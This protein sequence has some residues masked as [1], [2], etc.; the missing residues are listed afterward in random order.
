MSLEKFIRLL[1]ILVACSSVFF[2]I[3]FGTVQ[4]PDICVLSLEG[5]HICTNQ[6]D[7][8]LPLL[9]RSNEV[10]SPEDEQCWCMKA[11]DYTNDVR[12]RY[13]KTK[14][15]QP[16]PK[17]QLQNAKRYAVD[18]GKIGRLVHQD[19]TA[20]SR[21]VKCSRMILG[22]NIAYNYENGD[23]AFS[24]VQQWEASAGH[25][26]NILKDNIDEVVVG[27]YKDTN[28]RVYCVQT[29]SAINGVM[30][31][32]PLQDPECSRVGDAGD[33]GAVE[34]QII[35]NSEQQTNSV[36]SNEVMDNTTN[37]NEDKGEKYEDQD[38]FEDENNSGHIENT[39]NQTQ[40][41]IYEQQQNNMRTTGPTEV[42]DQETSS[43]HDVQVIE[44]KPRMDPAASA[45]ATESELD[46]GHVEA[47]EGTDSTEEKYAQHAPNDIDTIPFEGSAPED[48]ILEESMQNEEDK[49]NG[50]DFNAMD[51]LEYIQP[52]NH[53]DLNPPDKDMGAM[54]NGQRS[55]KKMSTNGNKDEEIIGHG[56][57]RCLEV[58]KR[59]WHSLGKITA[60]ICTPSL[61]TKKQPTSCKLKCCSFCLTKPKSRRCTNKVV[62]RLCKKMSKIIDA[63]M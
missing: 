32:E 34:D 36:L 62:K 24:C 63:S 28:G 58:G 20:A 43:M 40:E 38:E 30:S 2:C 35:S 12:R 52:E 18:L 5:R 26:E 6:N 33:G 46:S 19:L 54:Q 15:L 53:S 7:I 31:S 10:C 39:S 42:Y 37:Q 49:H 25:L 3:T 9:D 23:V 50:I 13:G 47:S 29:F 41:T 17:S 22:E 45:D 21:D 1:R 14:M 59:C 56:A 57:C 11:V 27:F 48:Q 8:R 61:P 60:H 16:G 51:E 44:K 55:K 4:T